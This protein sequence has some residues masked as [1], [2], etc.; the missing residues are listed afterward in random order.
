MLMLMLMLVLMLVLVL[1]LEDRTYPRI[2][3]SSADAFLQLSEFATTI[4]I[5]V[6]FIMTKTP[7]MVKSMFT[8][9]PE[10]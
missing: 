7:S 3:M 4:S 2:F 10:I 6:E 5:P 8:M 1:V 9:A